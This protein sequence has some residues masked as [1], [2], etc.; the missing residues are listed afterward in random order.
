LQSASLF[1]DGIWL[2]EL[3]PLQS[4]EDILTNLQQVLGIVEQASHTS[5]TPLETLKL[6]LY[7]RHVLIILDNCEHLVAEVSQLGHYLLI[8]CPHLHILATSREMLRVTGEVVYEVRPLTIPPALNTNNSWAAENASEQTQALLDT[9]ATLSLQYTQASTHPQL[10]EQVSLA[11]LSKKY[12]AVQL[13]IERARLVQPHFTLDFAN[14]PAIIQI[15]TKLDGVPLALE[16]A[17]ARLSVLTPQQIAA[18]LDE[19]FKLLGNSLAP[20]SHPERHQTLQALLEWSYSLL[21]PSEQSVFAQLSIFKG[22]WS[23]EAAEAVVNIPV[24]TSIYSNDNNSSSSSNNVKS[25]AF[26]EPIRTDTRLELGIVAALEPNQ[27]EE[28][29]SVELLEI[30]SSLVSKSLL[31]RVVDLDSAGG[32]NYQPSSYIL[33]ETVREYA[34]LQLLKDFGSLEGAVRARH[35]TFYSNLVF[36]AEYALKGPTQPAWLLRLDGAYPN[37]VAVLAWQLEQLSKFLSTTKPCQFPTT[38]L[39]TTLALIGALGSFWEQRSYYSQLYFWIKNLLELIAQYAATGWEQEANTNPQLALA[40]AKVLFYATQVALIDDNSTQ[41]KTYLE[42][43]LTFLETATLAKEKATLAGKTQISKLSAKE[44]SKRE[45][46]DRLGQV[47]LSIGDY[48][49]A[50][51]LF[52]A[53]LIL[54]S[55]YQD[56]SGQSEALSSLGNLAYFQGDYNK[57]QS[58]LEEALL[59]AKQTARLDLGMVR[60]LI[61]LGATAALQGNYFKAQNYYQ[62][63][64]ATAENTDNQLGITQALIALGV[65]NYTQKDYQQAEQYFKQVIIL[66]KKVNSSWSHWNSALTCLALLRYRQA[67]YTESQQLFMESLSLSLKTTN[68]RNSAENLCGLMAVFAASSMKNIKETP[69]IPEV[70]YSKPAQWQKEAAVIAGKVSNL[71]AVE[72]KNSLEPEWH[73]I[74]SQVNQFLQAELSYAEYAGAFERGQTLTLTEL[75]SEIQSLTETGI[76]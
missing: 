27:T 23:L 4:K 29:E 22:K 76:S 70:L 25:N 75:I 55:Q 45:I 64:L 52:E 60:I 59:Y 63:S 32:S 49:Q 26:N 9:T 66:N 31:Q 74:Y 38:E 33:L 34:Q 72:S 18:R 30:I 17:A 50:Q 44:I 13:F 65:L 10:D 61:G 19:R 58:L 42:K 41:A 5:S 54:S 48:V 37:I 67:N 36:K 51:T 71:L 21:A 15:C 24:G 12:E 69:E 2:V 3:A 8:N 62:Q 14:L 40:Y 68:L 56:K 46:L 16:L 47:C 28:A 20:R 6:A 43:S 53:S 57:A 73:E 1:P 39:I 7:Q 11:E 35:V